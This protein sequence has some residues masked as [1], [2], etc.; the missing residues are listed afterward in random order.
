LDLEYPNELHD[1]HADFALCPEVAKIN[2]MKYS[3]LMCNTFDKKNYRIHYKM[4]LFVLEH[5]LK[6]KKIHKI[7]SFN[8]KKWLEP[9]IMKNT[10]LR[11]QAKND[12]E[13]DYVYT[14]VS[15]LSIF[16]KSNDGK[17]RK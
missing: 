11:K 2:E 10:N 9:Y 14:T 15:K 8:E 1:L 6:L 16:E 12:F 5:G 17:K 3:K 7:V 13:K 4:L